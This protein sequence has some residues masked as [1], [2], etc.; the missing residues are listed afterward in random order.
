MLQNNAWVYFNSIFLNYINFWIKKTHFVSVLIIRRD[1]LKVYMSNPS[2]PPANRGSE[3]DMNSI[4]GVFI[5]LNLKT[6]SAKS[7]S[8][9]VRLE[10]QG[11]SN[12]FKEYRKKKRWVDRSSNLNWS[13]EKYQSLFFHSFNK[14]LLIIVNC[15][16][17]TQWC[18]T[19]CNHRL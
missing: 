17:V 14:Y 6:G 5:W 7:S 15:L 1:P 3:K 18:L 16:L 8:S 10:I 12:H 19:L 13:S 2:A 4:Y 9:H 11:H